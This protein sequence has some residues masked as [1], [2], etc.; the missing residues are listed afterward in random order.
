MELSK[1]V[2]ILAFL[3]RNLFLVSVHDGSEAFDL[4]L[5]AMALLFEGKLSANSRLFFNRLNLGLE[6]F[7]LDQESLLSLDEQLC[8]TLLHLLNSKIEFLEVTL[9]LCLHLRDDYSVAV[10]DVLNLNR[11][12]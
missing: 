3:A 8:F 12:G 7:F 5:Q 9:M 1:E 6:I 10:L 11:V 4:S 2:G